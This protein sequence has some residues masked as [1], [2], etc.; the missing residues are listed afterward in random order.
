MYIPCML[1]FGSPSIYS[2]GAA[3]LFDRR[4]GLRFWWSSG[5]SHCEKFLGHTETTSLKAIQC[6]AAVRMAGWQQYPRWITR[7]G[8]QDKK[9]RGCGF[10]LLFFA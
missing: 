8:K 7:Q 1:P 4:Q 10:V 3:S 6:M 5:L 9:L 2:S